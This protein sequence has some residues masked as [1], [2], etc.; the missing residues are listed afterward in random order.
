[1]KSDVRCRTRSR[2]VHIPHINPLHLSTICTPQQSIP[3]ISRL[4]LLHQ[5]S[6]FYIYAMEIGVSRSQ[7]HKETTVGICRSSYA[8]SHLGSSITNQKSIIWKK[9][10]LTKYNTSIERLCSLFLVNSRAHNLNDQHYSGTNTLQG[11][12]KKL[13]FENPWNQ[14]TC[15]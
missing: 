15:L 14:I 3:I 4:K 9:K 10:K 2:H 8:Q 5:L 12:K 6:Q 1:M 13:F 7:Q 11:C